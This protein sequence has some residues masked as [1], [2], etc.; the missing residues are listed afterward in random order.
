MLKGPYLKRD[1]FWWPPGTKSGYVPAALGVKGCLMQASRSRKIKAPK[2]FLPGYSGIVGHDPYPGWA[3]MGSDHQL[4]GQ[5]EIQLPKKDL[6]YRNPKG[7]VLEFLM[8]LVALIKQYFGADKIE[9]LH[10]RRVAADCPDESMRKLMNHEWE[11][12]KQRTIRRYRK[13]CRREGYNL[14]TF[15]R[16]EGID[17]G[18]NGVESMSRK[19]VAIRDDGGGNRSSEGMHSYC[20]PYLPPARCSIPASLKRP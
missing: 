7:D 6:K 2:R 8:Q 5:H 4:C 1:A 17:S 18:N 19:F 11:D 12:D 20:L 14:S 10:T 13:R 16:K 3:H 15:L 9:D